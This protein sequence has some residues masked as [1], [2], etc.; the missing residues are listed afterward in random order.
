VLF[1]CYSV[2]GGP[3]TYDHVHD[4][5][6][7]GVKRAFGKLGVHNWSLGDAEGSHG[8]SVVGRGVRD[9]AHGGED[10]D[11]V[12]PDGAVCEPGEV[13]ER[14]DLADDHAEKGPD[15]DAHGEA[16]LDTEFITEDRENQ[17]RVR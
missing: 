16:E 7:L 1:V 11:E 9:E 13:L 10:D 8:G 6:D 14:A 15:E 5:V 4:T 17:I 12:H 3:R 2:K